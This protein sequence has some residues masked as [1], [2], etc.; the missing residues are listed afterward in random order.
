[1]KKKYSMG[2]VDIIGDKN[3]VDAIEHQTSKQSGLAE[4]IFDN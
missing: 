4:P 3:A 1:M 2:L